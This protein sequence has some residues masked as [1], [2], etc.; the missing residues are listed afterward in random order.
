MKKQELEKKD[1]FKIVIMIYF[2]ISPIF[3]I[4]YFYNHY[5]TL[6]RVCCILIFVVLTVVYN[7]ESRKNFGFLVAY[8]LALLAYLAISY[9]HAK[10]FFGLVPSISYSV[11][12]ETMTLVKLAMPFSILFVLKYQNFTKED[13]FKIIDVWILLIAGSIVVLNVCGFSLSSYTDQF[14]DVSIFSWKRGMDM[15][16]TATKGLFAY[17]NQEAAVLLMLLVLSVY[18]FLCKNRKYI[19]FVGLVSL[20]LIM[21]GSRISTYGGLAVLFFV[22]ILFI[23]YRLFSKKKVPFYVLGLV[24]VIL[25][26]VVILPISPNSFRVSE[27]KNASN[28]KENGNEEV[29]EPIE[30][31]QRKLDYV[32]NNINKNLIGE[33]FYKNC[34]PYQYDIDFWLKVVEE[35]KNVKID[36]RT[37]EIMIMDRVWEID[38]R[39]SNL[40]FGLSN[41]RVQ[42]IVNV[43]RDF[44]L[45]F[46]AFGILGILITLAFYIYEVVNLSKKTLDNMSFFNLTIAL[47]FGLF[48]LAAFLSGNI[49]NFL[50]GV[51][52]CTFIVAFVGKYKDC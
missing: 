14:T 24:P 29:R 31:I 25:L 13:F 1:L 2:M 30:E 46:Y 19:V 41:S 52:P 4:I 35:Q 45:H 5:T 49:L 8:Y 15:R 39:S 3:D 18:E 42:S 17:T 16:L 21:L 7:K 23:G 40:L 27:I 36:Y 12:S 22:S 33:Q 9:F 44:I 34:Y 48:I 47:C 50:S 11:L 28:V 43:E 37:I 20:S 38:N 32:D 6:F 10:G 51:V 26:W